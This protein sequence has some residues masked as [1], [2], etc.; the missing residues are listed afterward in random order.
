[1]VSERVYGKSCVAYEISVSS[2][3]KVMMYIQRLIHFLSSKLELDKVKGLYNESINEGL[4][5]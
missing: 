4:L 2:L 1:M 5:M 3:N